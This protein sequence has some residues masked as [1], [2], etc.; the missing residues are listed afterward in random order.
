MVLTKTQAE[1]LR[2]LINNDREKIKKI[3]EMDIPEEAFGILKYMA[4]SFY[5]RG[6][7]FKELSAEDEC[8]VCCAKDL[9]E[10]T[11]IRGVK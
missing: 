5:W 10:L 1:N 4:N 6:E 9:T 8:Q 2:I 11:K 3:L 7:L